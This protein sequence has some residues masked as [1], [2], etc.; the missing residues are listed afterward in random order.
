[1]AVL[2]VVALLAGNCFS[3]PQVLLAMAAHQPAHGCCHR[4]GHSQKANCTTQSL[5]H[6]VKA[7]ADAPCS[8]AVTVAAVVLPAPLPAAAIERSA[9]PALVYHTPS[10]Q[11][12]IRV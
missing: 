12:P 7:D 1:M 3:C 11:L 8:P 10:S 4:G 5:R 6:F 9:V 2:V